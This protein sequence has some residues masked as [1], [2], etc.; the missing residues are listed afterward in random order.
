MVKVP[1]TRESW[2]GRM[3][4]CRGVGTSLSEDKLKEWNREHMAMLEKEAPEEFE[5]LH[6]ISIA[7]LQNKKVV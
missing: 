1:F 7:I 5:V 4:T 6:Y 2:N 3:R